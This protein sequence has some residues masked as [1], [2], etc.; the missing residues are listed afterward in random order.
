MHMICRL[1]LSALLSIFLLV[2][3]TKAHAEDANTV[4]ARFKAASGG[5]QWD[6]VH[7][8]DSTAGTKVGGLSGQVRQ[9]Q[10]LLTG[11]SSESYQI[12]PVDGADGYDGTHAWERDAGGEVALQ[13][14]PKAIRN[15]RSEAWLNAYAYWYPQRMPA[16]YGKV[17]TRELDGKRYNVIKAMPD[18]GDPVTLWF[19]TDTGLLA[20][21]VQPDGDGGVAT[22]VLDDYRKVGGVLL[23]FHF[24]NDDTDAAGR[25]DPRNH[26]DVRVD[27]ANLNATVSDSDFAIPVMVPTAH[28]NDA[29]GTT[30][31]PFDLANNHI[32]I[33]GA[34]DGKPVRLMFDTG[35]GN[36]LTPG[37][38]KRLGL[39]SK[40]KLAAGG[41]GEQLT[42]LGF[43]RAKQVR[44]GAA[45]LAN[46]VFAVSSLGDLPKVEG[47]PLDGLVGYEMFR[48]FG[49]MI[50]YAKKQLTLSEPK[51]FMPP[52]GAAALTFDLDE[53]HHPVIS[54]TLDG[55]PVRLIVDT[56]SRGSLVMTAA[57]VHAHDLVTKYGA[58]PE[59]VTG[60]GVNGGSRGR[61]ARFGTLRLGGLVINSVVG[62][63]LIGDKGG[64]VNPDWSGDLGGDVLR[65]FTLAFDYADKKIYLAPNADIDK[66]YAFDRSGL[67]L[68]VDG[69][70][71]KV[72]DVA[73]DS[74][75]EQA[76]L[77][78]ADRISSIDGVTISAKSLSD[79]RQQLRE[80]PV[81]T[82]LTIRF[83]RDGKSSEA[84]L[85]LADR[86]PAA[87]KHTV[88]NSTAD[89]KH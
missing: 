11:R 57:F 42:E 72:V 48:R 50:D 38:A 81:D 88:G 45:T 40:G 47:V 87:A 35:A 16:T 78:V 13:E 34:V 80:L 4:F 25:T 77:H 67:W 21:I 20:R 5:A 12:G 9:L 8:M 66:P 28:I 62:D 18:G 58:A 24:M 46:P 32:Y 84:T 1:S 36:Q 70:A 63:L 7:S 41:V 54:A 65:R 89:G 14:T 61:P 10:D 43:A 82:R 49:V 86:I 74:A 83:Q 76:G 60:W 22:T 15:A 71:L 33:D 59:A 31:V 44:V 79:W 2:P 30:R 69:D 85:T 23:P 26:Q 55:M 73:K 52:P 29:S 75:A 19:A 37:A 68:F 64:L 17:E 3:T 56:G 53:H 27:R 39:T 6:S 51:K